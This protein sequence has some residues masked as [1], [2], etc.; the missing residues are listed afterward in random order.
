[1]EARRRFGIGALAE[2]DFRLLFTATMI[3][4][5]GDRLAAI[6][7]A[8][9]VL[10]LGSATDLGI[11]F[12]VRQAVNAVVIVAGGVISDR[13]PRN[14]VLVGASLVQG[15]AQA[16]TAALV[17]GGH[18]NL[19]WL[20]L[21]Q[22]LYGVGD[23]LVIPAEVGLLPQTV[24]PARLQQAN[25]LQGL[26][27]NVIRVL[28]PVV[29]AAI[30]VAA[31]PGVALGVDAVSFLV[32]A[33]ILLRIRIP[34]RIGGPEPETFWH[35]LRAGWREFTARTWLWSAVILF[36]L[37]NL[38][39]A[40]WSVLGP[41]VAK[42]DLG[43]AGAWGAILAAGGLG[44]VAGGVLTLR[45]RPSRPL[46][47]SVASAAIVPVQFAALAAMSPVWVIALATFIAGAAL[48][49]HLAL[50][51]TV[52]QQQVPEHAQSRVSSYDSLGSFVLMPIGF[53][54]AGSLAHALGVSTTLWGAGAL[55]LACCI[56]VLALPSVWAIRAAEPV[57]VSVPA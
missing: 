3:T 23:G 31:S 11:V 15:V 28:G 25:A 4:T 9:A 16:G 40:A 26:T 42:S 56:G 17:L 48:A 50:W 41:V 33:S 5:V 29:G 51:F 55:D 8:F 21:L 27:R 14:R 18:G 38:A 36:G 44:S 2:R 6:A 52:F 35:E 49:V 57:E 53:V 54:L 45:I 19:L 7:L 47:A 1:V 32:C 30:V 12:G 10:D 39:Y 37:G 22:G 24:S 20:V 34:S 46:V 43:G 13:L